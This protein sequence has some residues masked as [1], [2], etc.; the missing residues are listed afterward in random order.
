MRIALIVI[1]LA[2]AC[3]HLWETLTVLQCLRRGDTD[4]EFRWRLRSLDT[5]AMVAIVLLILVLIKP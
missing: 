4:M 3:C 1:V 5:L 2:L